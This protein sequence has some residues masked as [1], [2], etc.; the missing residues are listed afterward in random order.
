MFAHYG[1]ILVMH[2]TVLGGAAV[3]AATHAPVTYIALMAVLK[4]VIETGWAILGDRQ[5]G[6][7]GGMTITSNGRTW[8]RR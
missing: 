8:T 6:A 1:R 5:S 4:T 3:L 7:G 2:L